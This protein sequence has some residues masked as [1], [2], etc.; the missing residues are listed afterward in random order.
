MFKM[1]DFPVPDIPI[2]AVMWRFGTLP[3]QLSRTFLPDAFCDWG[4]EKVEKIELRMSDSTYHGHTHI[5]P[6]KCTALSDCKRV[7]GSSFYLDLVIG[8][9]INEEGHVGMFCNLIVK[10]NGHLDSPGRMR[11][12]FIIM[13]E[14]LVW[15]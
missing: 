4:W 10:V 5:F 12:V 7:C 6:R 1:E 8:R 11:R 9:D 15:Q 13:I 14:R 3:E 2:K